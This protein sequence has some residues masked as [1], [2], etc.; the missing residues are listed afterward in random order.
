MSK[1]KVSFL[2]GAG[3]ECFSFDMPTGEDYQKNTLLCENFGKI[4]G[5]SLKNY[6]KETFFNKGYK[7]TRHH[8]NAGNRVYYSI[9]ENLIRQKYENKSIKEIN[10][11]I[12]DSRKKEVVNDLKR[13]FNKPNQK[14]SNS[15][16]T[17]LFENKDIDKIVFAGI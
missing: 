8:V 10:K 2:F 1:I 7:Y 15:F 14:L 6:F 12:K 5:D 9:L 16:L 4:Y 3:A 11:L 17:E 13:Y